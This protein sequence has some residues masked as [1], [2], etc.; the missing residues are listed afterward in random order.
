MLIRTAGLPL[1]WLDH[2]PGLLPTDRH[3]G[4]DPAEAV[5]QAFDA[6]FLAL[7]ESPLRTAVYNARRD[8]FRR[9]KLPDARLEQ[10]LREGGADPVAGRLLEQLGA[11]KAF[12]AGEKE[13]D[14]QYEAAL[15]TTYRLLQQLA[16]EENLQRALLFASHDLLGRLPAFMAKPAADFNKKDRQTAL[17]LL[18]YLGR[19]AAKT[20]PLSR[21]TTVSVWRPGAGPPAAEVSADAWPG[22]FPVSKPA[23]TPNVALL[24]LLYEVLLREPVF[25][26]RLSVALNPGVTGPGHGSNP[27]N[28][29]TWLYFDGEQEAFQEIA[30]HPVAV[31][32]VRTLLDQHRR[33]PFTALLD[34]LE[35]A[36]EASRE[37]LALLLLE[38][39]DMGLLEWELPEKGLSPGWCGALYNFLGFLP[40][41]PPV[42]V[43]AAALLQW[44]RTSARTLPF[45]TLAAARETQ[46]EAVRQWAAFLEKYGTSMPGIPPE[47]IFFEDVEENVEV[48]I[49]EKVI[50]ELGAE[51]AACWATRNTLTMPEF[52]RRLL[53]FAGKTLCPDQPM[54]FLAFSRAFLDS[55][56]SRQP[57]RESLSDDLPA[58]SAAQKIGALLQVYREESGRYRA[59]VNGMYNGGG[60][61]FARWLHLFPAAVST[62]VRDWFEPQHV[63]FPWQGWSNANFQ[64]ALPTRHLAVPGGRVASS[65]ASIPLECLAVVRRGAR[66]DLIDR[67]SGETICLS[68]LGL[69]APDAKPPVMRVLWHLGVPWVSVEALLSGREWKRGGP[70]WF[71]REREEQGILVLARKDWLVEETPVAAWLADGS[72]AEIFRR[73]NADLQ[74]MDV[75][76]KFF[77]RTIGEKPQYF[78]RDNPLSVELLLRT[79]RRGKFPLVLT[80]MLPLPQQCTVKKAGV[81]AAELVLELQV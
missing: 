51:L 48:E 39:I 19:A 60:K 55:E 26:Q 29:L 5:R 2:L 35:R 70:G 40:E 72:G 64:P 1:A 56:K 41:P 79:I 20:S 74:G 63:P 23:V 22:P 77:A 59:V 18:Q 30:A 8:F 11:F 17:S 9:R 58:P 13:F 14:G 15:Q 49:P 3:A 73:I 24:P 28:K 10:W 37:Q 68:D 66:V 16:Q 62:Q 32:V 78:D 4:P 38:L 42:V 45:Q 50:G 53:S 33:L 47:Q 69:E 71:F 61:L 46:A 54:D 34:Q 75:P 57:D 76:N 67:N 65:G 81:C 31:F 27:G 36:V 6:A 25:Y 7:P 44:M 43:E 21:F 52:R 80:E 12:Q